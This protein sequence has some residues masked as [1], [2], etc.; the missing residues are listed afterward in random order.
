MDLGNQKTSLR[1]D[2]LAHHSDFHLQSRRVNGNETQY[3]KTGPFYSSVERL[4]AP[5][6]Y[7]PKND[8]HLGRKLVLTSFES[9]QGLRNL[10]GSS[11]LN[12]GFLGIE[13]NFE[14]KFPFYEK[15]NDRYVSQREFDN[16][17]TD[18]FFRRNQMSLSQFRSG[19]LLETQK[20]SDNSHELGP[21]SK[22]PGLDRNSPFF[23]RETF[24]HFKQ[25]K[26]LS[27]EP[28]HS[29]Q[30]QENPMRTLLR[31]DDQFYSAKSPGLL[32]TKERL[33]VERAAQ[34][35]IDRVFQKV[36]STQNFQIDKYYMRNDF[37]FLR[38]EALAK[39]TKT[40]KNIRENDQNLS[41]FQSE[42]REIINREFPREFEQNSTEFFQESNSKRLKTTKNESED[43]SRNHGNC[44]GAFSSKGTQD[45]VELKV[46]RNLEKE[47]VQEW[48]MKQASGNLY[49]FKEAPSATSKAL[50]ISPSLSQRTPETSR[51][52]VFS[53]SGEITETVYE[54][55][56]LDGKFHGWGVLNVPP[57]TN[58]VNC[59]LVDYR[60]MS[61]Y[62]CNLQ[63]Y[64]GEFAFGEIEGFGTMLFGSS[65]KFSGHF[66]KGEVTGIG[67]FE[68]TDEE[69]EEK[70]SIKG[71]WAEGKLVRLL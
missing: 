46:E 71:E 36:P 14:A 49:F 62:L 56:V 60:D 50:Q 20:R 2:W 30:T 65:Q 16:S 35:I 8:E 54:G 55:G 6:W 58:M 19:P 29:I 48:I 17:S 61:E 68:Q 33:E 69:N 15:T 22:R 59:E 66:V 21:T 45:S 44:Q 26:C 53:K 12:N 34:S 9:T 18:S 11:G 31:G 52:R 10:S 1:P 3:R 39:G 4:Q 42:S 38:V 13:R 32:S 37:H 25:D 41:H 67:S 28:P 5:S 40:S 24:G 27:P 23:E 63:R 47:S 64:E 70:M 7:F 43:D 57:A 51:I